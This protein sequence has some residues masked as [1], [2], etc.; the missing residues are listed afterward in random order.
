VNKSTATVMSNWVCPFFGVTKNFIE[1]MS[2]EIRRYRR[3]QAY[4]AATLQSAPL[5]SRRAR[6]I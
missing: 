6:L 3:A 5:S 4:L 1:C 2:H